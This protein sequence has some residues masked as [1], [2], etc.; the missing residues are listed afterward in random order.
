MR[1]NMETHATEDAREHRRR[2]D[3]EGRGSTRQQYDV[4]GRREQ[5]RDGT[6]AFPES[7]SLYHDPRA[8]AG[9]RDEGYGSS[10]RSSANSET[11]K[12]AGARGGL[13]RE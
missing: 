7:S 4:Y 13:G 3:G 5:R 9:S 1:F 11:L 12:R 10:N 8:G 2:R 6:Y